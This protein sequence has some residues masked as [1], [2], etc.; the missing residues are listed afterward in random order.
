[1]AEQTGVERVMPNE[2]L[3][4]ERLE[5][6]ESVGFAWSASRPRKPKEPN[7]RLSAA[8]S[9]AE[10][11]DLEENDVGE[12]SD[13]SDSGSPAGPMEW[14]A[15]LEG[16]VAFKAVHGHCNVPKGYAEDRRLA[17]W[18]ERV[19]TIVG[20]QDSAIV[21]RRG[22]DEEVEDRPGQAGHP[23]GD[24]NA[25]RATGDDT[26][27]LVEMGVDAASALEEVKEVQKKHP[28]EMRD[29]SKP[30]NDALCIADDRKEKLNALGFV[31]NLRGKRFEDH[32]D[33]MFR[34]VRRFLACKVF[35]YLLRAHLALP[36]Q[37]VKLA[38]YKDANGDCLVPSR[39]EPNPKLA[40]WVETQVRGLFVSA[41]FD[42][43]SLNQNAV[44]FCGARDTRIPNSSSCHLTTVVSAV[45]M[46][47]SKLEDL[48]GLA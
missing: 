2:R 37:M 44:V 22:D 27:T 41:V 48:E 42:P 17:R 3:T 6:L 43:R 8:S 18:V 23:S 34:Q 12:E 31:W 47:Q 10:L 25:V 13:D 7:H 24:V 39:Y 45:C 38:E 15:M 26:G 16:L 33:D 36:R 35:G 40:K 20:R 21:S 4:S 46:L 28:K 29:S 30:G 5:K 19:R 11:V 9:S 1:V 14:D 32:W